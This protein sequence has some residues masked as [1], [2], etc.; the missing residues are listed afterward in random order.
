MAYRR[1]ITIKHSRGI[2]ARVAA[3]LAYKG[4]EINRKYDVYIWIQKTNEDIKIPITSMV[5]LTTLSI[6][7][8]DEIILICEG[9][10]GQEALAEI[11]EYLLDQ[12]DLSHV[13][14]DEVDKVIDKTT[15]TSEK[16]FESLSNGIMVV[17]ENNVITIFNRAAEKI[18]G[19]K[20]ENM[21]GYQAHKVLEDSKLHRVLQTGEEM[22]G[23]RQVIGKTMIITNRSPIIVEEKIIG[24]VAVFQD[25]SEVERLSHELESV[26]E[27]KERF[28]TILEHTHDAISMID[29]HGKI[30]YINPTFERIWNVK[31]E[32]ILGKNMMDVLPKDVTGR[33]LRSKKKELGVPVQTA[34]HTKI[35]TNATPIFI[36]GKLK[37]VVSTGKEIT[38][39][40]QMM[41]KLKEAE[42]KIEYFQ[43]ELSRNQRIEEAFHSIIGSSG[44]LKEV[45]TMASKAAKTSS[46]ILIRGES[47]TGKELLARAIHQASEKKDKPFIRVNCAAI[48]ENLLESELFGHEKGA[49]TGAIKTKLGKFE[50]ANQ[51]T[52][53][54]DEIGDMNRDLQVKLLRVLQEREFERIGGLE[55]IKINVRVIAATNKK[56]E[57]MV[58]K[59]I[60]REDLYYRLNV[61]PI[62]LPPLRERKGDIPQLAEHF[63]E[64]I[65][66]RENIETKEITRK[67]L[68]ALESYDWPGNIRELENIIE[69]G[70]A[71][72][73]GS[74][75]CEDALPSYIRGKENIHSQELINLIHDDVAPL[76][77]YE[78]QIIQRA[79]EKHKTFNRAAKALGITHRTVALKARK[80]Q[81]IKES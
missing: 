14:A 34:H 61:I 66:K 4:S 56:L 29:E 38:E 70:L 77:V 16:I 26:R 19:L 11:S 21:I 45:L 30:T 44:T 12:I 55:T 13:S 75:L 62:N 64:K 3:A 48:P 72:G 1:K 6:R 42:E 31:G 32:K 50:L 40:Q 68:N 5:A 8:D 80:Y 67:A 23:D 81:L 52:I 27:I 10:R 46:T 39:L 71:L 69:R 28:G 9:E 73:E 53:F 79:L 65:C 60:F 22:K 7:K 54:L 41:K 2:H 43:Q 74:E 17:D 20:R 15:L 78:K 51:G 24:A 49:F 35:I 58:A 76:E 36:D 25:M 57:E 47:G 63:I 59:G 33:V 18:T 37:G